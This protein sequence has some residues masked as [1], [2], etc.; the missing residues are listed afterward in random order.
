MRL[1][2]KAG[3]KAYPGL[4][5][6]EGELLTA[7]SNSFPHSSAHLPVQTPHGIPTKIQRL[8]PAS[9]QPLACLGSTLFLWY[10]RE[11]PHAEKH[12]TPNSSS[13]KFCGSALGTSVGVWLWLRVSHAVAI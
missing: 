8:A 6:W 7:V 11:Y 3:P 10:C 12:L 9:L 4:L 2:S 1:W 13:H 5:I